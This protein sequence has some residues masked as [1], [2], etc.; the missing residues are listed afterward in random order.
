MPARRDDITKELL[1]RMY[2][3]QGLSMSEI[4]RRLSCAGST[5]ARHLEEHGI[6]K[7]S[8]SEATTI[9]PRHDFD[10]RDQERAYLLGFC[11]GD[12]HVKPTSPG[13][14]SIEVS[15]KTTRIEQVELFQSLFEPYGYPYV[16]G[17]D[18]RG[19]YNLLC[20]LNLSFS[21]L[22]SS[23]DDVPEWIKGD[24]QSSAAFAAGYTDA[25]GS[26]YTFHYKSRDEWRSGFNV[27]SQQ[28]NII[29]WFHDWLL[30]IGAQCPVP[31]ADDRAS[32]HETV[33]LIVIR[34]MSALLAL[35]EHIE[36]YLRHAKRRADMERVRANVMARIRKK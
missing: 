16:G 36:P 3:E 5:I 22:L 4:G 30:S 6:P 21:F 28:K 26:F 8:Q 29:H 17:P 20:R 35:I 31:V 27:A 1:E 12:L 14:H 2:V 19:E 11:L 23:A 24:I 15:C 9:Y 33:W 32:Y 7:R 13:C 18:E 34:R 25:E 10:G